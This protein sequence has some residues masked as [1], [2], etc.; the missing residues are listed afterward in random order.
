MTDSPKRACPPAG[1]PALEHA[2][3]HD[4]LNFPELPNPPSP[5]PEQRAPRGVGVKDLRPLR[6][7]PSGPILDPNASTRRAQEQ[8]EKR[9]RKIN[10]QTGG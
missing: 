6:G 1:E 10:D 9:N 3:D 7:R 4:H 2:P 8:P 5:R